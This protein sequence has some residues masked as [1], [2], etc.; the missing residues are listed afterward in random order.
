MVYAKVL[1]QK[2]VSSSVCAFC[3]VC[4]CTAPSRPA[5]LRYLNINGIWNYHQYLYY[6]HALVDI[7]QQKIC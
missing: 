5:H 4:F 1:V 7:D 6:V 3:F 2:V